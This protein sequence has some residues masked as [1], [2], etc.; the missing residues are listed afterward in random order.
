[1]KDKQEDLNERKKIFLHKYLYWQHELLNDI[2]HDDRLLQYKYKFEGM[3]P[4]NL[5]DTHDSILELYFEN[6]VKALHKSTCSMILHHQDPS[7]FTSTYYTS[8]E[9]QIKSIFNFD[10]ISEIIEKIE[11]I[12]KKGIQ[13]SEGFKD[14]GTEMFQIIT[15][16]SILLE[17]SLDK[18]GLDKMKASGA[19][20]IINDKNLS[21]KEKRGMIIEKS[22]SKSQFIDLQSVPLPTQILLFTVLS[23]CLIWQKVM[24]A[25]STSK[26]N[27]RQLIIA[28]YRGFKKYYQEYII[29]QNDL[30][31]IPRRE[32]RS[33]RNRIWAFEMKNINIFDLAISHKYEDVKE[34]LLK[35]Y[36]IN[37]RDWTKKQASLL[38]LAAKND[39]F[40]LLNICKK[41]RADPNVVDKKSQTAIYNALENRSIRFIEEL[42]EMGID[43]NIKD[44]NSG[45]CLYWAVNC[46]NLE[47]IKILQ[48]AGAYLDTSN[49][50][51]RDPL[52]KACFLDKPDVVEWLL[53][54]D[55]IKN[56]INQ[57]DNK[58]RTAMHAA[59]WGPKGGREGKKMNGVQIYD[60]PDSLKLLI[61]AGADVTFLF[62]NF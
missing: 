17:N 62:S 18:D 31:V 16:I 59:C 32:L 7:R 37:S 11:E 28:W 41:F 9:K 45:S 29:S 35:G 13:F 5:K 34:C 43:L 49:I 47:C 22:I 58:G 56:N 10:L 25:P 33:T 57:A 20:D 1:M 21:R 8:L 39:D 12:N 3:N 42:I 53:Q 50:M 40:E 48:R 27:K 38:H 36:D 46:A 2:L 54:F 51:K 60:S 6:Q 44:K 55:V 26:E 30:F 52:I 23:K 19:Q 24:K 15:E 4:Q 14:N 61:E